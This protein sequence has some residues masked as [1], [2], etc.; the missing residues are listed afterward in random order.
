MHCIIW[1][2]KEIQREKKESTGE[3]RE[4]SREI[5]LRGASGG[6]AWDGNIL[7]H[8]TNHHLHFLPQMILNLARLIPFVRH[9]CWGG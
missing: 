3:E 5:N 2:T 6:G 1:S 8:E 9:Y 7:I 4:R